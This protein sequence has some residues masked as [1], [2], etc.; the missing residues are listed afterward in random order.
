MSQIQRWE[1]SPELRHVSGGRCPGFSVVVL[2]VW[3]HQPSGE[4]V[5]KSKTCPRELRGPTVLTEGENLGSPSPGGQRQQGRGRDVTEGSPRPPPRH[6]GCG[7]T[8][9]PLFPTRGGGGDG[10]GMPQPLPTS[11]HKPRAQSPARAPSLAP[12]P[13]GLSC[14]GTDP[15]KEQ[16]RLQKRF[17][18]K[19]RKDKEK[20]GRGHAWSP[21]ALQEKTV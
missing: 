18:G 19:G 14:R 6:Q 5:E 11:G 4:Q 12:L 17:G 21:D 15:R 13:P 20:L 16:P 1:Q 9:H 8:A 10:T 2:P 7:C 3:E